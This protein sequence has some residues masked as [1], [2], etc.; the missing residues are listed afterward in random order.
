M[1]LIAATVSGDD[2]VRAFYATVLTLVTLALLRILFD[3]FT[4]R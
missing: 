4:G 2:L 1:I 3:I